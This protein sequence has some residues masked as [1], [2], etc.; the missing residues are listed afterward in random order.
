MTE[1]E[2]GLAFL[3]LGGTGEIGMNLNLYRLDDTWLAIDC[4]IGFSGNDTPEAE[5]LTPDPTFIMEQRDKLAGLVITHAHEDHIG[6]VAHLWSR[7]QCPVYATPFASVVLRRKLGEARL[8]QKV[9]IHTIKCGGR[10]N[11][12]P[13]DIE[14][15][16]VTHSV[17]E[18]QA[19]ALRTPYGL[20][21]HTGDWKLDPTP[22][23]GPPTDIDR[24]REIGDEGVLALVGDSTNVM[25]QGPSR[26]EAEVREGMTALIGSLK[27]RIAVTCFASNVARVETIAMAAQAA[28]RTVVLV[29][30]SLRNLDVAAREC[31]YLSG[32]LPFLTEQDV[33]NLPDDQ[34]VMIITGSQGEP[35]S[36]LSRIASDVHPN[37]ALGEG[38]TVIYSSRMI[39]GNERAIMQVQDNLT[40]RGVTVLT[41][42]D[43]M[44]HCSGHATGDDVRTMYELIRPQYAVPTHG[45]WRH[46]T[47]H[48]ALAQEKG[49]PAIL[50]EDGD[51]LNLAPG[52]VEVVDTAPTGRLAVDGNRLLAMN[53]DVLAARRKMLFNGIVLAS[54]A[55]DDEG[56]VIGEPKVSA[57]GLLDS[58]EPENIRVREEFANAIDEIPDELRMDDQSFREAA[59]T[60]L[61]R[62][63]GRK[64][65][66]RPL[67]DVHVLRV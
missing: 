33:N 16:P 28:G 53:G 31:G 9:K 26:S 58:D 17:P 42:R 4:G 37:V 63:L 44:V 15:I 59:K 66:K 11:V 30:R 55:V 20:I 18:A 43:A 34:V 49:I 47:A 61:R 21:L 64:I 5:I 3:P 36:A 45:E 39:P 8:D 65:Q 1:K 54:F 35:R 62:A 51:I 10:F 46:L 24:L 7:L 48:A 22:L 6:A 23:V 38:D 40:R 2:G 56:Y 60:A 50:L 27:G 12:G 13:F 32:V 57:P 14:F 52:V 41:D 25:T 29:G 19:L 67:V